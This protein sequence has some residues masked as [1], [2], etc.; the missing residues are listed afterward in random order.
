MSEETRARLIALIG[1]AVFLVLAP[2][3]VAAFL[4]WTM[5]HWQIQ[6]PLLGLRQ[7]AGRV[8]GLHR[9]R[10]ERIGCSCCRACC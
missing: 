10:G 2:G 6:P 1:S 4:P 5:T 3:T 7:G 8:A 9:A